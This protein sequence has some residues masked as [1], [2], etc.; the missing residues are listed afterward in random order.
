[1]VRERG[2]RER[3]AERPA[4]QLAPVGE[5]AHDLEPD[6]IAQGGEHR[7][8]SQL[9]SRRAA[10]LAGRLLVRLLAHGPPSISYAASRSAARSSLCE[11]RERARFSNSRAPS[12][13]IPSRLPVSRWLTG[14]S[15][16][17]PN[18]SSTTLRSS[19]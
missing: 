4:R 7:R 10:Q 13:L 17:R 11:S 15:G 8:E 19:S 14:A 2:F 5:H 16:P 12:S 1:M 9:T 6:R 18:L 3:E